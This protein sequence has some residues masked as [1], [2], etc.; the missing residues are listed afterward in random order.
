[1]DTTK[2]INTRR[3]HY[4]YMM[5]AL[6]PVLVCA[7][8][9]YSTRVLFIAA[10][11]MLTARISDLLVAY[12]RGVDVDLNDKSSTVAALTFR[13]MLP[14]SIPMYMVVMT[15]AITILAGKHVFGGRG[16]Y[17]FNLAALAMCM[18]VVNWPKAACR[19]VTPFSQVDFLSGAARQSAS[20]AAT[21]RSGGLPYTSL[22]NLFLGNYPGSMGTSFIIIILAVFIAL[23]RTK[24]VTWHAPVAF[25]VTIILI[26]LLFPRISGVDRLTSIK[27]EVLSSAVIYYRVFLLNEP[28]TTPKKNLAKLIFGVVCGILTMIFRYFG[29]YEVG[30]CFAILLAN[31]T[32]G[33]WDRLVP[34]L[35]S[36][37]VITIYRPTRTTVR[38][39][40]K[41]QEKARATAIRETEEVKEYRSTATTAEDII[42]NLARQARLDEKRKK[43]ETAR[44]AK[45]EET[46]RKAREDRK[47]Q[48][49]IDRIVKK[50]EIVRERHAAENEARARAR[51]ERAKRKEGTPARKTVN[52]GRKARKTKTIDRI[53]DSTAFD[54]IGRVEDQID[55]V[56]Y[57]TRTIDV[58]ELLKAIREQEGNG[59]R[60]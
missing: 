28:A 17:P 8:F 38:S 42:K 58:A 29:A 6:I 37:D 24:K 36:D 31:A 30:G 50:L 32:E 4:D 19:V 44:K 27:Y 18:A 53:F 13:M 12:L 25:V 20:T 21:I 35:K 23:I 52:S 51:E 43:E 39:A 14:V 54:I 1:M 22:L 2:Q 49:A 10:V 57:S 7:V 56:E 3:G 45:E 11:A 60:N 9:M 40:P 16:V 59:W 33:M 15:V 41:K 47:R 48:E 46:A 5:I 55:E 26:A 34:R